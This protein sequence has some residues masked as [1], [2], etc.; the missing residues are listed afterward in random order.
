LTKAAQRSRLALNF[1]ANVPADLEQAHVLGWGV[2]SF[3]HVSSMQLK[4][5]FVGRTQLDG[6]QPDILQVATL[7]IV[8][9]S[10]CVNLYGPGQITSE[11]ICAGYGYEEGW[12]N[13]VMQN[14]SLSLRQG[15]CH[16]RQRCM[17]WW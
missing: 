3:F 2:L 15:Y 16:W 11:M 4:R 13:E 12:E 6:P 14:E 17:S 7:P 1:D 5:S 8:P 10:T 9:Q